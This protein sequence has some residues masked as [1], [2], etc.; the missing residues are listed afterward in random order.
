MYEFD[1]LENIEL[2]LSKKITN[3]NQL[4]Y[5]I[6]RG[7]EAALAASSHSDWPTRRTQMGS[8]IFMGSRLMSIGFNHFN[9]ARPGN[10]F[11]KMRQDGIIV[12]YVK[13][14]HAEQS[15][16]VK[17]R[18][19][20]YPSRKKLVMFVYRT[21]AQGQPASSFPC[22]MCQ[23]EISKSCISTVHFFAPGGF[24]GYWQVR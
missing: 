21:D 15:A 12:E 3:L 5:S 1:K 8:A 23:N 4:P 22:Q 19:R 14:F 7:F 11:Y 2:D 6:Q 9:K 16:L 18:Y 17:I 10:K 20:E 24:Y 13:P